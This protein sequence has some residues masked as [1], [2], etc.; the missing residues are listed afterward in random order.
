MKKPRR[1]SPS[2][3]SDPDRKTQRFLKRAEA[4]GYNLGLA[5]ADGRADAASVTEAM[6]LMDEV[7]S[8]HGQPAASAIA[9][10]IQAAAERTKGEVEERRRRRARRDGRSRRTS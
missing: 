4:I 2:S 8:A 10:T 9:Y 5:S 6:A 1:P 3:R 7:A